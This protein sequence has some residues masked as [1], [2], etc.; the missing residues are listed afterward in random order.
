MQVFHE[1]A[2][3]AIA[4]EAGIG[5]VGDIFPEGQPTFKGPLPAQCHEPPGPADI[6]PGLEDAR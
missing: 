1:Q 5:Q 3:G 6:Y 2:G 4:S